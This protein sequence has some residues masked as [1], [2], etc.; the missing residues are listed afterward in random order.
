MSKRSKRSSR[1]SN[2]TKRLPKRINAASKVPSALKIIESSASC[3]HLTLE[4]AEEG[5]KV[6]RFK[7]TAYTG[8]KLA[9]GN[10][11]HPVVVDLSGLKVSAKSRPILRDH[12]SAQIVGHTES[13]E[14]NASSIRVE[15]VVSAANDHAREIS[16][17]SDNGFPWQASIGASVQRMTF[18]D[19]GETVEV[20]GRK[21]TG[22][23]YVARQA[24]LGEVSFVALG[25]DDN[26]SASVAAGKDQRESDMGFE[27]WLKAKGFV[28]SELSESQ[29]TSLRAM[30]ESESASEDDSDAEDVTASADDVKT[31]EAVDVTSQIRADASAEMERIAAVKKHAAEFPDIAAKAIK[32]GWDETK[33]ELEV[34]RASR[35]KAPAGH[36][37]DNS[38]NDDIL[39]SA[40]LLSSRYGEDDTVE[41]YGEKAVQ[42]A[43]KHFPRGIGL[44]ELLLH[45]A[46]EAGHS[47]RTYRGH[48]KAVLRAAFS[49]TSL[50]SILS[51]NAN[52][53]LL[54]G[55][56]GVE[57]AWR[58]IA[59]VAPVND[60]KTVT[61][62]R[63]TGDMQY[64]KVGPGGELKDG[65]LGE[66]TYTNSADTY[67]KVY[68]LTRT[69]IRNDDMG[70]FANIRTR[71][72]RGAALAINDVF[73]A[74]FLN[75]SSFFTSGRNNYFEGAA[76]NL[77]SS[78]LQTAEQMLMDQTDADGKPLGIS[79]AI[80]LVPTSI[81]VDAQELYVSTNFNTGGSSTKTKVPD[82]NVFRAKYRPVVSTYLRNSSYTGYSTTAWYLLADPTDLATIQVVFLDGQE[83][84]T[85]EEAEADF[86]TLGIQFRGYHDF[87]VAKT[88]YRAGVKSK[89]AA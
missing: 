10:F 3:E 73:W 18:V 4:A 66:E 32:E 61:S 72:G 46:R 53:L 62:H 56:M 55:F 67:G 75:N 27:A 29:E 58:E 47:F 12:N 19:R 82:T 38:L 6:R 45:A 69:H 84:P 41:A 70:A 14:I 88:E 87:G 63:L 81:A 64:E 42:A 43:R 68:S 31:S 37:H 16:E 59:E 76:T 34:M 39:A 21:F 74:E 79:G 33:V 50:P 2:Q 57:S 25:A 30:Y 44:Q 1:R 83:V 17:S 13:V 11:Y 60:F 48:E 26:T 49:T 9:L 36:V 28:L 52:K 51:N 71:L 20:N 5:K 86:N 77:Q 7:M 23:L 89:G 24:T 15:G 80:L 65:T 85:I 22:P 8:G 40:V 78:S 35:P 54:Q